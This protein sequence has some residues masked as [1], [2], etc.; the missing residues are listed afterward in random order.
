M[1]VIGT[2]VAA[3]RAANASSKADAGLQQALERLSTGKRINGAKDDAA[4][5]AISSKMTA[6][7]RG[8]AQASRNAQDGISL[9][10]TAE[11]ALGEIANIVQ[12]I[13]EL[14]VQSA[15]GT[16]SNANRTGIKAETDALTAQITNIATTTKFNGNTLSNGSFQ[17][18]TGTG[19]TDTVSFSVA[20][21]SIAGLNLTGL[22]LSTAA[23]ATA[24][25]TLIDGDSTA[26]AGTPA[27]KGSLAVISEGRAN[28]G[29]IQNRL[30]ATI[31]NLDSTVAN[32]TEA[33]SRIED[34]DFSAETTA[35]AKQQ[36]LSQASTAML[37]QANQAQQNV[38][39]LIR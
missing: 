2:N 29:G 7:I 28:L 11:G 18:Q 37:A 5:L 32:L 16:I 23:G 26:T 27:F 12:R 30:E 10:Q 25:L 19:A 21:M 31:S 22:D 33:R 34:A 38:L 14:A 20:N 9:T 3:L 8:L 15:N 35:L 6:D 17:L 4:G 39:S 1:T 13:R 24:A 36:I